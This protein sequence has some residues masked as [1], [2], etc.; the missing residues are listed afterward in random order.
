MKTFW[1]ALKSLKNNIEQRFQ[2][3][4]TGVY[5]VTGGRFIGLHAIKVIGWGVESDGTPYWLV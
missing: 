1:Y 4:K 5:E 3:Y 2:H